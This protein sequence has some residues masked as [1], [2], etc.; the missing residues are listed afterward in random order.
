MDSISDSGRGRDPEP[1]DDGANP[2]CKT[3]SDFQGDQRNWNGLVCNP[4]KYLTPGWYPGV[5]RNRSPS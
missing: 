4:Q 1:P 3:A 2:S 5:R